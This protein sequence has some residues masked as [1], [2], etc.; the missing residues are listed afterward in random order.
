MTLTPEQQDAVLDAIR[1]A[2]PSSRAVGALRVALYHGDLHAG[3][4]ANRLGVSRKTIERL[5]GG[6]WAELVALV[7]VAIAAELSKDGTAWE[8]IYRAT[9][10]RQ[11]CDLYR[12]SRRVVG[13]GA[14][15]IVGRMDARDVVTAWMERA[16]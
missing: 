4:L 14:K 12:T 5:F 6:R 16:A 11:R 3:R 8:R 2:L 1:P 10:H 13:L 9:G 7:R 15:D